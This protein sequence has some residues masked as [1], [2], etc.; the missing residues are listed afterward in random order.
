MSTAFRHGARAELVNKAITFG[1]PGRIPVWFFNRDHLLGDVLAY[2]L[3]LENG[4]RNEWGYEWIRL[5]DGTMGQPADPV[6]PGWK[7]LKTFAVPALR[8]EDRMSGVNAFKQKAGD[9]YLLAS[10]G[11]SGFTTYSFLRGFE[12]SMVDFVQERR[13]AESLID[14][15]VDFECDLFRLAS[16]RGFHGVHLADDWGT[17]HGLMLHPGLW[18]DIFRPR[19]EKQAALVH[20]LGMH[21]WFHSCG[22]IAEIIGDLH[23]IGVDVI[24][25]SQPNV[26]D[27][28]R[29]G[30]QW[31]GQ[32]CF[33]APISYQTVSISGTPDDIRAE[34][35]RL[36]EL[37]GTRAGGFIGYVEEY[38]CM[39]MSEENYQACAGSFACCSDCGGVSPNTR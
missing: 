25:I 33:M 16:A 15:I 26:V 28:N 10:L 20:D 31:R 4:N 29:T 13:L 32:Q 12:N 34:A 17:Q 3:S 5:D 24:N 19:Y 14:R 37:L 8:P 1:S 6:L 36:V 23:E 38:S 27:L 21:L 30:S 35:R 9:R 22:N 7:D 18:R 39:G 2:G 11:I